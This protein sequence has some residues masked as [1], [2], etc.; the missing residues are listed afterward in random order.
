M[1]ASD[2]ELR[3]GVYVCHCGSNIAGKIDVETL[4]EFAAGLPGVV[5]AKQY[6]YMCSDPGQ[7]LIKKDIAEQWDRLEFDSFMDKLEESLGWAE[8]ALEE[9]DQLCF[10]YQTVW[11]HCVIV[12]AVPMFFP[13]A[14]GCFSYVG[15]SDLHTEADCA[16]RDH[17]GRL[18]HIPRSRR[19]RSLSGCSCDVERGDDR[20]VASPDEHVASNPDCARN[21]GGDRTDQWVFLCSRW[22]F[23]VHRNTSDPDDVARLDPL[24]YGGIFALFW[25]SAGVYNGC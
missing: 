25:D 12:L 21:G 23:A 19:L 1:I 15:Q 20:C 14:P 5:L 18:D 2:N 8:M 9:D 10:R 22:D 24:V 6:K 16:P 7:E 13:I 4:A 3:I 17:V 11:D